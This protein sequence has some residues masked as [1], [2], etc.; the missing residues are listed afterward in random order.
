MSK[1]LSYMPTTLP[2]N[3]IP[4]RYAVSFSKRWN[5]KTTVAMTSSAVTRPAAKTV[6][7]SFARTLMARSRDEP[8]A[9]P[10]HELPPRGGGFGLRARP[11]DVRRQRVHV[12]VVAV[13]PDRAE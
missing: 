5:A 4:R 7:A 8:A 10:R 9:R 2:R 3:A 11:V 12:A 6:S 1:M 13:A